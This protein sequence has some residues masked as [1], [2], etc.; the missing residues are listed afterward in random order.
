MFDVGLA[1][2]SFTYLEQHVYDL[3]ASHVVK[4][5]LTENFAFESNLKVDFVY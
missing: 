1:C 4:C 2:C 3:W 5:I